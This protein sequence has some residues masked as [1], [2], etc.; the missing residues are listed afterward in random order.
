MP[1]NPVMRPPGSWDA[2]VR[3]RCR[4]RSSRDPTR[5]LLGGPHEVDVVVDCLNPLAFDGQ[6]PYASP[7]AEGSA[8]QQAATLLPNSRVVGTFHHLSAKVLADVDIDSVDSDV[9]VLG[10]VREAT[11]LVEA[12][13][14]IIRGIGGC[15]AVGCA[16]PTGLRRSP[17][18]LSR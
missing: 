15:M 1:V 2:P 3:M 11:D 16:M 8:L 4:F 6:G 5:T 18:T 12:V 17:P 14:G 13:A 10:D 7:V 9:L